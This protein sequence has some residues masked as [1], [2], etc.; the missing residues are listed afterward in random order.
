MLDRI[1]PKWK[2]P[3][4]GPPDDQRAERFPFNATEVESPDQFQLDD[5][6]TKKQLQDLAA[7][8]NQITGAAGSS[9]QQSTKS[10]ASTLSAVTFIV[11][12]SH[13]IN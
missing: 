12:A 4:F 2:G 8:D 10:S 9:V 3:G 13:L 1:R 7:K 5:S 6:A 11:A